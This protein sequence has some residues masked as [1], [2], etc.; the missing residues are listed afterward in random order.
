MLRYLAWPIVNRLPVGPASGPYSRIKHRI[1][2]VD[3]DIDTTGKIVILAAHSIE[4]AKILLMSNVANSSKMVGK[5]LMDHAQGYVVAKTKD[6]VYPFRG[7]LTTSGIDIFRDGDNRKTQSAFR[8][9]IGNDGWGR[10]KSPN[11]IARQ[12]ILEGKTGKSLFNDIG[13][14]IIRLSRISYSTE[15]LPDKK[16][17]VTLSK[18]LDKINLPRPKLF[19]AINDYNEKAF[20]FARKVCQDIFEKTFIMGYNRSSD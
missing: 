6:P 11:S 7:P 5:N 12:H 14:E 8:L 1:H 18:H 2:N 15:V 17:A 20:A 16:N 13:N 10:V 9:S 4:S 19:F 3:H